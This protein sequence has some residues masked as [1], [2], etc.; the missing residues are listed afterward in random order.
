MPEAKA[1]PESGRMSAR[2]AML[3]AGAE[4]TI[5]TTR[6][7]R[8][9]ILFIGIFLSV[10]FVVGGAAI[11]FYQRGV[12]SNI[13]GFVATAIGVAVLFGSVNSYRKAGQYIKRYDQIRAD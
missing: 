4:T 8:W 9:F 11:A 12:E 5:E 10:T 1:Q 7:R 2:E 6:Q 13:A 3:E